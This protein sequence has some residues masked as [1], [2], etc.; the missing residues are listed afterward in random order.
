MKHLVREARLEHIIE[1]DSAGTGG[2]HVGEAPDSRACMA[3]ERRGFAMNGAARQFKRSDWKKFDYVLAM[4]TSNLRDLRETAPDA[5]ALSKLALLRSFDP[6]APPNAPVPDPYYGGEDG[7]DKVLDLCHAAC[8]G[9][10][11]HIR[12]EHGL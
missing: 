8:A 11:A 12:R 6:H 2:Y 4:D 5:A 9:L 10:L 7:F 1:V 3:A